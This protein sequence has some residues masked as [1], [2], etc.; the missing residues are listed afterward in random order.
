MSWFKDPD[1]LER[2]KLAKEAK[3]AALEKFRSNAAGGQPQTSAPAPRAA[4]D[5]AA[6]RA[7]ARAVGAP[8]GLL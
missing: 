4:A 7:G 3:K 1:F 2:Q 5:A 6:G 8:S